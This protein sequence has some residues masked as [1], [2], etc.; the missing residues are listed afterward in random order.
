[1]MDPADA[2]ALAV[3][4]LTAS[5]TCLSHRQLPRRP[6]AYNGSD[7]I[8]SMRRCGTHLASLT[9]ASAAQH[10]R[11]GSGSAASEPPSAAS[12]ALRS[13]PPSGAAG[14]ED[15]AEKLAWHGARRPKA[16]C[17]HD[18]KTAS[19]QRQLRQLRAASSNAR[20]RRDAM[21]HAMQRA[22]QCAHPE[23]GAQRGAWA[24][25]GHCGVLTASFAAQA[26]SAMPRHGTR[27]LMHACCDSPR[28]IFVRNVRAPRDAAGTTHVGHCA[29]RPALLLPQ[30]E[31]PGGPTER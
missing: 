1:M 11:T 25:L 31:S 7:G 30:N 20:C 8:A 26:L 9:G 12:A 23:A 18:R 15:R 24:R 28:S 16:R 19:E 3:K 21:V 2:V 5:A 27:G 17:R 22:I 13:M 4:A 29:T 10:W 14:A 6:S